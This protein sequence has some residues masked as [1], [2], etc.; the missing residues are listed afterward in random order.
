M[1]LLVR[2]AAVEPRVIAL[3]GIVMLV[4]PEPGQTPC[5]AV[6][7]PP[8]VVGASVIRYVKLLAF[9]TVLTANVPL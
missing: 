3:A 6:P 4:H 9:G 1:T 7:P 2:F 5:C 8:G